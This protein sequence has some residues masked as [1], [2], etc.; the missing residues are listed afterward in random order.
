MSIRMKKLDMKKLATFLALAALGVAS[1]VFAQLK[2]TIT[3][4]VTDPIPIA[5]V[6][7]AR[8]VPADGGIDVAAIVQRDLES[9]GRFK[10]MARADMLSKPTTSADIDV[11]GFK[12]QRNDYV[13][14]GRLAAGAAG[15]IVI[16]V[17]LVNVLT[18]QRVLG[19]KWTVKAN[20]LRNGAHRVA[21]AIYE[22]V[23]GVRGAFATRIA[24]VSVDGKA[25]AQRYQLIV[26]DADGESPRMI[27]Q[28]DRPIMSP[29]W[30]ADGDWL[31]YVSFE[32]RVSAV[33]VQQVRSGTR[34]MVSA[35]AGING[36]PAW[37]PD[38]KKLAL[39]LSGTNGN[40][41]VYLLDLGTQALTRLTDDP[42]IDTEAV[43]T[44]DGTGLYFTSDRSGNPQIYKLALGSSERPRRVTF[45][46]AYNARP[47]ISPDGKKLAVL[48]LDDGAYRIGIQ[49]VASGSLGVLSKGR[50]DESPSFA[51]NGD[52]VI[53]AG[54][55]RG[56]GVLQTISIDGQTSSRL[57]ADAGEVREPVWGPFLP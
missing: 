46:G 48:T 16:D 10:G 50:Q 19:Q 32:R 57:N 21:D 24:Y 39:T 13:A 25:P 12:Q 53:L 36:S 14:V 33:Y 11:A 7:F 51:P 18:G 44:P 17:E 28:S 2:L 15:D 1:P 6:P 42:S 8:A 45:T 35:R 55:E 54:R 34:R 52:M 26:A 38:G 20:N 9:S 30:S 49:D 29:A 31:A 22:K 5:V 3:Q 4:G 37:S 47:R 56:Q 27:L 23:T 41:D 40:L 43:F